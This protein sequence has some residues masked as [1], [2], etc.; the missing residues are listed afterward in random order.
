MK[1][2]WFK[3]YVLAYLIF[4]YAPIALLPV[5]AFND[6]AIVAY[7]MVLRLRLVSR[8]VSHAETDRRVIDRGG[9]LKVT[10][11]S[12]FVRSVA[13]LVGEKCHIDSPAHSSASNS[14]SILCRGKGI[15]QPID[16]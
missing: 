4:L 7:F 10:S 1:G 13:G 5:F 15:S 2:G 8:G 16:I 11:E 3:A 6:S 14:I 12:D 9:N